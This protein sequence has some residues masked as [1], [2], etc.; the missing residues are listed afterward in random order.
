MKFS[1]CF[2]LRVDF[3]GNYR[4]YNVFIVFADN[5]VQGVFFFNDVVDVIGG[6]YRLFVDVDYD[7]IF[8]EFIIVI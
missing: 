1:L 4:N 2:C 7:V 3:F 6:D 5:Y 8:F